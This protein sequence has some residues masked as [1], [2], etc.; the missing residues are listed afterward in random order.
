MS[1]INASP[2]Q[3]LVLARNIASDISRISSLTNALSDDVEKLAKTF[4]DDGINT[5][6]NYVSK[7]QSGINDCTPHIAMV[8]NSLSDYAEELYQAQKA[9]NGQP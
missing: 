1:G 4:Q 8:C 2:K 9:S 3:I 7:V 6:R 5:V